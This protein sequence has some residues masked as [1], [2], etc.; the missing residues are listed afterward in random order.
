MGKRSI[1]WAL[2]VAAVLAAHP[3]AAVPT[4]AQKC[5]GA[6]NSA[7]GRYCNCRQQA[8]KRLALTG[9]AAKYSTAI[10]RCESKF[11]AQWQ[12]AIDKASAAGATCPDAPLIVSQ[13]KTAIDD[14][15]DNIATALGGGGLAA[16]KL[17]ASGQT[18]AYGSGS[19]GA[20]QAGSALSYTDNGDGTITDNVTGLMW[21][22]K[23]DSGGIHD[24]DNVY[25]WGMTSAPYTMN[26]T[27]V[28]TF[29][30]TLNGG[31]GFAGHTDWRIPNAKELQSI[32]DYEVPYPGPVVNAAFNNG[33]TSGCTVTTCSCTRSDDYWSST[34][35][36]NYEG[37]AWGVGFSYGDVGDDG[38]GDAYYV[39]AVR[40]GL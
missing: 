18:T 24:K 4:A 15:C 27:M 36:R 21:E 31:A 25:T 33:C 20:V 5:Q 7:A 13:Y 16:K 28:T 22:K 39:R 11:A 35:N 38:K 10:T 1:G 37:V 26:G 34:T 8:E 40:G 29:L 9:D 23:D 2:A 14:H 3:V 30:A 12:K 19:D 17:P 32:V 6:K